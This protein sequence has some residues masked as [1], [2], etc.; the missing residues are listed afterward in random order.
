M[1]LCTSFSL[2]SLIESSLMLIFTAEFILTLYAM[3]YKIM[4]LFKLNTFLKDI[5]MKDKRSLDWRQTIDTEYDILNI[6]NLPKGLGLKVKIGSFSANGPQGQQLSLS[7]QM[8]QW[9]AIFSEVGYVLSKW[10]VLILLIL[11]CSVI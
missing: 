6:W 9:P 8:I 3:K 7:E 11:F 2:S 10:F 4:F 1:V 5:E